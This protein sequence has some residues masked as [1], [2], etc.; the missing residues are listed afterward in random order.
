MLKKGMSVIELIVFVAC[1][2][3]LSSILFHTL[4]EVQRLQIIN[5]QLENHE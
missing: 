2:G 5:A 1:I 3:I 4:K